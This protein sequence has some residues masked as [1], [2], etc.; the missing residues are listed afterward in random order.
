MYVVHYRSTH[1]LNVKQLRCEL[2]LETV[3]D[4]NIVL[5]VAEKLQPGFKSILTPKKNN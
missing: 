2:S 4:F 5:S 1:P 3:G